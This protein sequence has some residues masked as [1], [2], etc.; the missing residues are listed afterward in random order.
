MARGL[1]ILFP[2]FLPPLMPDGVAFASLSVCLFCFLC[3]HSSASLSPCTVLKGAPM[4][5]GVAFLPCLSVYLNMFPLSSVSKDTEG[6]KS[7]YSCLPVVLSA[8][9]VC[10]KGE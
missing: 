10:F 6:K 5:R 1:S 2:K 8:G 3:Y 7:V 9:L 4:P